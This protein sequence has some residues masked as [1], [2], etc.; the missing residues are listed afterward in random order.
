MKPSSEFLLTQESI[1]T[2]KV[3]AALPRDTFFLQGATLA[4]AEKG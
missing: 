1:Q 3:S 2:E 4:Q